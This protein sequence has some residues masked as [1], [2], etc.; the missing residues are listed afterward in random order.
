MAV[1]LQEEVQTNAAPPLPP[2]QEDRAGP[3]QAVSAPTS[4]K[5]EVGL[6]SRAV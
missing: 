4:H 1:C 2:E 6:Q 5:L 3:V